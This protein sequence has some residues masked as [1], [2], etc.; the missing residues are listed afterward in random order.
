MLLSKNADAIIFIGSVFMDGSGALLRKA[1]AHVPCFIINAFIS[2]ENIYC[3]YC[4]DRLAVK[5]T[6]EKLVDSG[7]KNP[8]FIYDVETYGSE[9]KKLGFLD[10]MPAGRVEKVSSDFIA[11]CKSFEELFSKYH[12]DAVI[13]SNDVLAAAALASAKKLGVSVPEKLKIVGHNNSL[14]SACTSPS[15]TSIDNG[16]EILSEITADN[17]LKLFNGER[18]DSS[19]EINYKLIK[20]ESF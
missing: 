5:E 8:V 2:G 6:T 4:N 15:L 12:H 14:I 20:R 19:I 16:A 11:A 17:L 18:F 7:V 13:C 9:K 10:A 1:A 3:A